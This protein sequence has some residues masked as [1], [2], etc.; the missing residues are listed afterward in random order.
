M[1]STSRYQAA[2]ALGS[3]LLKKT[4][5]TPVIC[6]G[7]VSANPDDGA[8]YAERERYG[9]KNSGFHGLSL[10]PDRCTLARSRL[11]VHA[12][13]PAAPTPR[14]LRH[15][16]RPW[17]RASRTRCRRSCGHLRSDDRQTLPSPRQ[18]LPAFCNATSETANRGAKP[19]HSCPAA[20]IATRCD[21]PDRPL[22]Q[23]R[24]LL[25]VIRNGG[26]LP[27]EGKQLPCVSRDAAERRR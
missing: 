22:A 25:R 8:P 23:A 20:S 27:T 17:R 15:Q 4:P 24:C 12:V 13:K 21:T 7:V 5:P 14:Q 26:V 11:R 2:R 18:H 10:R 6:P 16:S 19:L 9:D 1:P 3:L